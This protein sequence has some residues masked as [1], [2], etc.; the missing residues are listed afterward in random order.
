MSGIL[1]LRE[2]CLDIVAESQLRAA[3]HFMHN[4]IPALLGS[5]QLW[6]DSGAGTADAE[7]K[8]SIRETIKKTKRQISSVRYD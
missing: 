7:M 1:D 2:H 5:L 4:S 8:R 6:I 3:K